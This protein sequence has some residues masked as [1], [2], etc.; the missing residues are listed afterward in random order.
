[1]LD[2]NKLAELKAAHGDL[3][4]LSC[5][6]DGESFEA[7]V[8]MP[9]DAEFDQ[10]QSNLWDKGKRPYAIRGMFRACCVH[11]EAAALDEMLRRKPGLAVT[12]GQKLAEY[13]GLA[14]SVEEEKL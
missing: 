5:K 9:G 10:F 12:F 2:A 14:D 11:P 8:R 4:R 1:M 3:R 7:V 13:A 6:V